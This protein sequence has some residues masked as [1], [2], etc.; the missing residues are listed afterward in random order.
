M[1]HDL[2]RSLFH[3]AQNSSGNSVSFGKPFQPGQSGN[4]GGRP[5]LAESVTEL[6]RA[7]TDDAMKALARVMLDPKSPPSSVVAASEALLSRGWGKPL[8]TIEQTVSLLDNVS[9]EDKR[10]VLEAL[11]LI[12]QESEARRV[13]AVPGD[14]TH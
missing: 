11:A 10:R 1:F 12:R 13:S 4:P 14:T 3:A 6:A 9:V 5:K 2:A 7:H 8:A